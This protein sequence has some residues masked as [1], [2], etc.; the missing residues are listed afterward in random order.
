MINKFKSWKFWVC[1]PFLFVLGIYM[2]LML[3]VSSFFEKLSDLFN[4]LSMNDL[5]PPKWLK[6]VFI[7][8]GM[9]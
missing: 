5:T 6:N 9:K 3:L 8:A 7:F 1:I 4:W 2:L